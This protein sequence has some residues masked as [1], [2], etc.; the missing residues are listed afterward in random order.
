M[1]VSPSSPPRSHETWERKRVQN[2]GDFLNL[3][4]ETQESFQLFQKSGEQKYAS[5]NSALIRK[6]SEVFQQPQ[7]LLLIILWPF[8]LHFQENLVTLT[9]GLRYSRSKKLK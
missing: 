8:F 4:R 3:A 6:K 9:C 5:I 1:V 7:K 2:Y